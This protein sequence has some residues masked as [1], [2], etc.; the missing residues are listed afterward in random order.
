MRL[1]G[2]ICTALT[3][4]ALAIYLLARWFFGQLPF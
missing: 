3:V 4:V 2:I 1:I